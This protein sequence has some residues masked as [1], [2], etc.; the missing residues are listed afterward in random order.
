MAQTRYSP[1]P[2]GLRFMQSAAQV[3][4]ILG[5]VGSGKSTV[6]CMEIVR[7][8]S[9]QERSRDG[10]RH[11]RWA[12]V[13]NTKQ[14]LKD[15]T[16]KTWLEWFPDGV[17][18]KWKESD[19]SY[20]LRFGDVVAEVLFRAL[21]DPEDVKRLLSL[22]LTG[23]YINEAREIP[24][25]ILVALRSR[26]GRYPSRKEVAPTWAGVIMDTNPPD[27]EHW[28]H[29]KFENEK[30]RGWEI[31]KQPG[32][33]DPEAE[34]R[35]N[36]PTSYYED[37]MEGATEDW[38]S[39]HVHG[40][41]GRSK[42]GM[43][44]Y[45]KV[46]N[47]DV[48]TTTGLRP[49]TSIPLVIGMDFGRTP[50]ATFEQTL[51]NGQ[52]VVLGEVVETNMGLDRF[53]DEKVRPY[54]TKRFPGMRAVVCAD[55]AGWA[56]AQIAD[57][58]CYDILKSRGFVAVK[59]PTNDPVRR[60]QSVE[61]ELTKMVNGKPGLLIDRVEA[62]TLVRGFTGGYC[63]KKLRTG[64]SDSPDKNGYS[65]VHDARQYASLGA[66]FAPAMAALQ[67]ASR[68]VEVASMAGWT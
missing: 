42:S 7:R 5:P 43:P 8:A 49:V 4:L 65:H 1:P 13:R 37:M 66:G 63:Y 40:K 32:G 15:T 20:T 11:T 62:P 9:E 6:C 58:S 28:I 2:T 41:Y 46:F 23:A 55:P 54:M 16:L 64:Y 59:A 57:L 17:A 26:V 61:R 12:I 24:I 27:T 35:E 53:L 67:V 45:D 22:E 3:R 19:M 47:E 68:Q 44:V 38:I 31:F 50:A 56:K 52:H 21:D 25:E 18:G 14:Q 34:N 39:V 29:E 36:L 33:L 30:P 60:I 10:L 48:H 51:P